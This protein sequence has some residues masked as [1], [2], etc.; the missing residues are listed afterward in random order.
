MRSVDA[1]EVFIKSRRGKGLSPESIRWYS[2]L[3]QVFAD[4]CPILPETPEPIYE[5]LSSLKSGDERK[6]GYY[7]ALRVLYNYLD[8]RLHSFPNPMKFVDAPKRNEK[9]PK[10][11][12]PEELNKLFAQRIDPRVRGAMLFFLDSGCRL[13]EFTNLD[14]GNLHE[15]EGGYLALV[16]GKTGE[17]LVPISYETY[18]NLMISLP[19]KWTKDWLGKL[20][21]SAFRGAGLRGG[22]HRLR[23]TFGTFW[24]GDEIM[25]QRVLGHKSLST[26]R[27]Y[28]G[29]RINL[30]VKQHKMYT[31]LNVITNQKY[32]L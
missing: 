20:I 2:G 31:P 26:T 8:K 27:R 22:A 3:L 9:L 16:R 25:L 5:F 29:L 15:V 10:P 18:H 30:M 28:R 32:M 7:R 11:L 23:H 4:Y 1:V 24:E 6:H 19:I 21:S 14:I 13:Q 12:W 17:R